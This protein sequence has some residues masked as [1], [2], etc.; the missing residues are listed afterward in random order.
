MSKLTFQGVLDMKQA[1][2]EHLYDLENTS[3]SIHYYSNRGSYFP[4]HYAPWQRCYCYG[5][6][7]P[8][9]QSFFLSASGLPDSRYSQKPRAASRNPS[10]CRRK[11]PASYSPGRYR[12]E[13]RAEPGIFLPFFQTADGDQFYPSCKSGSDLPYPS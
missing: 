6:P 2:Y 11:L 12:R 8:S 13:I 9:D 10:I 4:A 1:I 3:I 5:N 7:F